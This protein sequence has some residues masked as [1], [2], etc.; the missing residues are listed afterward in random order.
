M[1]HTCFRSNNS[2][3][4]RAVICMI[5]QDIW[6]AANLKF[7]ISFQAVKFIIQMVISYGGGNN[8]MKDI[9]CW[10][11][12]KIPIKLIQSSALWHTCF[13]PEPYLWNRVWLGWTND[14]KLQTSH[15][16]CY[17]SN[18]LADMYIFNMLLCSYNLVSGL[19]LAKFH[20]LPG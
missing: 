10:T 15:T 3:S 16:V 11:F 14:N 7:L 9:L 4:E 18:S 2:V 17:S 5:W 6:H 12:W 19:A 1:S 8:Y 13:N 20:L